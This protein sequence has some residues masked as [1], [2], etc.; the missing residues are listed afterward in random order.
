MIKK[1]KSPSISLKKFVF[2]GRSLSSISSSNFNIRETQQNFSLNPE[3][4]PKW[5][6]FSRPN[7]GNFTQGMPK[8]ENQFSGDP[9]LQ[10]YLQRVLPKEVNF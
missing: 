8:L 10:K 7:Y 4:K 5:I 9:F 1:L 2:S 6:P 3:S